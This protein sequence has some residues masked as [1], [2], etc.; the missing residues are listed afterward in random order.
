[1]TSSRSA[2]GRAALAIAILSGG[3]C[4]DSGQDPSATPDST[5][6][7]G[8]AVD[9]SRAIEAT[10][11]EW[12]ARG[13]GAVAVGIERHGS[14][15]Q[16][17]AAGATG[18][19]DEVVTPDSPF[20]VGSLSKTVVAVMVLQLVDEGAIELDAPLITYLPD[21]AIPDGITTRQLLAHRSGLPEHTDGEL[22]PAVLA[23]PA[24]AWTPTDVLA[25][26]ADQPLD[27]EPGKNFGYSNTN[28]IV[29]G[30]LLEQVTGRS[31]TENL[32]A[33]LVEP[34]GLTTTY[35]APD[36]QRAPITGYSSDLAG[37]T[38]DASPYTAL[39]TA[40]GAAGSLV[41]TVPDLATFIRALAHGELLSEATYEEMI[42][43]LPAEGHSLGVFPSDPPTAT[44]IA[45]SGAIP[46]FTAYMQVDPATD[47]LLILLVSDDTRDVDAL[48]T[49][50]VAAATAFG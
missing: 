42:D 50:V 10:L 48:G 17:F 40:A 33:R 39:E 25:L 13:P 4:T 45:N 26:V 19:G 23:D 24:R 22:V 12:A 27:F 20:R 49:A 36:P 2:C 46:G 18:H 21:L 37:G 47:D 9:P 30:L 35:F 8:T 28:Y 16:L 31:L 41:S 15:L 29:A 7:T 1:M 11:D 44:G 14:G 5:T 34:L 6:T 32:D 3:G 38:T 43:G